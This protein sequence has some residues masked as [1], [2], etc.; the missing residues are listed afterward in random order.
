M[1]APLPRSGGEEI[2]AF[3]RHRRSP[4]SAAFHVARLNPSGAGSPSD[5]L[6]PYCGM[7]YYKMRAL[8]SM[9]VE[10]VR[11]GPF[12]SM[13]NTGLGSWAERYYVPDDMETVTAAR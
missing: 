6:V 5:R 3:T 9:T 7:T 13:S 4:E 11:P 2:A 8:A 12:P 1:L 10:A